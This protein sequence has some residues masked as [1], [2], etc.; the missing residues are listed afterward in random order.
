[1]FRNSKHQCELHYKFAYEKVITIHLSQVA[2]LHAC[3]RQLKEPLCT[4]K[5][6]CI[7]KHYLVLSSMVMPV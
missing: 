3:S 7:N 5:T 4:S 2:Q 1:M 6:S